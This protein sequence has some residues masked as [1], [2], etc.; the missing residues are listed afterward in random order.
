REDESNLAALGDAAESPVQPARR[1]DT[2]GRVTAAAFQGL[3][4]GRFVIEREVGRGGVG[5]VYRAR[6][7]VSGLPVALKVIAIPGVDA[8]EEA[9]FAREGRILAGLNHRNIVRVVG[10]GQLE[11]GHPYVAMEW[12]DGE[13]IAQR[14]KR[15][16][17]TVARALEIA[18]Q[19]ADALAHAH[20]VGIV[21][22]DIKP[23]NVILVGNGGATD[24]P[25]E[26]KLVDFGVASSEDV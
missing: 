10:F 23:S 6:D 19:I 15:S 2:L 13:D 12:L 25:V 1:F 26:A 3:L 9:R 22:R 21:H 18:A 16:P 17:L 8:S 7:E 5:I 11:E 24:W 4:A 14:Q 20:G